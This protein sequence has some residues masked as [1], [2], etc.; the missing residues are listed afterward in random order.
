[1][2]PATVFENGRTGINDVDMFINA[3]NPHGR[4]ERARVMSPDIKRG[5]VVYG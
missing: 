5:P 1:V 4:R 2:D 3:V